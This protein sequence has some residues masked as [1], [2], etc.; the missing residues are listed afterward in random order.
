MH[1]LNVI[2]KADKVSTS[3]K[4]VKVSSKA[5]NNT[6]REREGGNLVLTMHK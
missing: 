4:R 5:V 2:L 3:S 1:N 6:E